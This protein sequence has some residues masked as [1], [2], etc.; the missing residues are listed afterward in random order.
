MKLAGIHRRIML[1][2]DQAIKESDQGRTSQA[3][4]DQTAELQK[5]INQ[6][7]ASKDTLMDEVDTLTSEV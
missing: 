6:L 3:L 1:M 4:E 7:V 5:E 2:K